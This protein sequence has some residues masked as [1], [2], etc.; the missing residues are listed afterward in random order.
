MILL[1]HMT[2]IVFV[3]I[4]SVLVLVHEFGHYLSAI[5]LKITVE[6]FAIGFP[7]RLWSKKLARGTTISLNAIPI[8][9]YVRLE[10]E[11]HHGGPHA[12]TSQSI[13]RRALVIISGVAMN[14]LLAIIVTAGIFSVGA[15]M[16]NADLPRSAIVTNPYL[17]IVGILPNSPAQQAELQA[18]ERIL[19]VNDDPIT[20]VDELQKKFAA[21]GGGS[22]TIT[23]EST[24]QR[25]TISITPEPIENNKFGIGV[26]LL[27]MATVRLPVEQAIPQAVI[28]TGYQL[29]AITQGIGGLF[30]EL[31]RGENVSQNVVGPVGITRL[32]GQARDNG[33]LSL[34]NLLI[35]LSLNL[36]IVNIL[37]IPA[38]DG[39]RLFFLLL[40]AI[41]TTPVRVERAIHQMGFIVLLALLLLI[42]LNDLKVFLP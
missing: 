6:E 27:P 29:R 34:L 18:G 20:T 11:D 31:F 32:V 13:P 33:I 17:E 37:P 7:P 22:A 23:L 4:F 28:T 40:S 42:T 10:G 5:L 1:H 2:I 41:Y 16:I 35:M 3:A 39:G 38:L 19:S 9:G 25:R 26:H 8:G 12:F 15:P 21:L 14:V 24:S 36:A 30:W